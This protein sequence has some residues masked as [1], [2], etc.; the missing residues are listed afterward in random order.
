MDEQPVALAITRRSPNSCVSSLT[1]GVS[2]QPSHAPENSSSG[3]R[4]WLPLMVVGSMRLLRTGSVF[5]ND[6]FLSSID[7]M[8]PIGLASSASSGHADTHSWQPVQS[9]GATCTRY[10]YSPRP[11]PLACSMVYSAG[12]PAVSSGLARNGRIAAC[13]HTNEQMLHCV[14]FSLFQTGTVAAMA[15][16]SNAAVPGGVKPSGEKTDTGRLSPSIASIGRATSSRNCSMDALSLPAGTGATAGTSTLAHDAGTSI[17]TRL[18]SA[19]STIFWFFST[20]AGPLR[21]YAFSIDFFS[22]AIAVSIGSTCDSPK[23]TV[24]MTMLMNLPRPTLSATARAST[25]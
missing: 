25:T 5:E 15:R 8:S 24:C 3:W 2:P 1:Y 10:L 7:M 4:S 20:T 6:Q 22:S 12:A 17:F 23:K 18:S 14:Q 9:Y 21:E 13:G 16:R 19:M 11:G